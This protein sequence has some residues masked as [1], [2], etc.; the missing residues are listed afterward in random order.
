MTASSGNPFTPRALQ[1]PAA[2]QPVNRSMA[3]S[4][5]LETELPHKIK[6]ELIRLEQIKSRLNGLRHNQQKAISPIQKQTLTLQVQATQREITSLAKTLGSHKSQWRVHGVNT[7]AQKVKAHHLPLKE[8]HQQTP[9][10]EPPE[11]IQSDLSVLTDVLP[12]YSA[13]LLPLYQ[14][15]YA[16]TPEEDPALITPFLLEQLRKI[17]IWIKEQPALLTDIQAREV[18]YRENW[19]ANPML[20][21]LE[22]RALFELG[23]ALDQLMGTGFELKVRLKPEPQA[24]QEQLSNTLGGEL[25]VQFDFGRRQSVVRNQLGVAVTEQKLT[26]EAYLSRAFDAIDQ[27][28]ASQFTYLEPLKQAI[29][30]FLEAITLYK[31]R[32][33]AYFGLGYLY[34]LVREPNNALYFLNIA[35]QIS[36]HPM[37]SK[38]IEEVKNCYGITP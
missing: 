37:I 27:V 36:Q 8:W 9:W 5:V 13:I 32:Y 33:E 21:P 12:G 22:R 25:T 16:P 2:P 23:L 4:A 6:T 24:E 14:Q 11:P 29:E 35:V 1:F 10:P 26:Y 38:L 19:K 30:D 3:E 34:S 20:F 17:D 7:T 15:P 28:T 18:Q 31:D